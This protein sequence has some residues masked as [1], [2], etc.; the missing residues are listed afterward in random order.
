M[1]MHTNV[2]YNAH[3]HDTN[4]H[5]FFRIFMQNLPKSVTKC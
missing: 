3:L 5:E 4:L 1:L 2:L